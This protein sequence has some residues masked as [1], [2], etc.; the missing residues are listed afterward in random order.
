MPRTP[1]LI[2]RGEPA[3]YHI[4]SRTALP[5]FVLQ[6][7]EKEVLFKIIK[8]ISSVY[9]VDVLGYAIMG[10]H[11]H[12]LVRMNP[13]DRY[14]EEDIKRRY[15]IY[16]GGSSR[17]MIG[18][19]IG[20]YREKWSNLSEYVKEIKQRFAR[21]YNR[22][23]NRRGYFWGDRFK[24][25][26]VERGETLVNCLAYIDLN[27]VRAGIVSK[28]EEYRWCS[29]GYHVQAGN[30]DRFLSMDYGMWGSEGRDEAEKLRNYR[31]YLYE[32]G[33]IEVRGKGKIGEKEV[34]DE[35]RRGYELSRGD[36]LMYRRRYYTEGIVLGSKEFVRSIYERYR[37]YFG[38]KREREPMTVPGLKGIFSL[39]RVSETG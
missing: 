20:Y 6:D 23:N 11:F 13:G 5:G 24:S 9:F 37:G 2:V 12:L 34:E 25:V 35:R 29:I 19:R 3:V 8:H 22:E 36:V 31:M 15:E 4:I 39:K 14:T 30:R 28:P 27:A 38:Y 17:G 33:C 7:A 18:E 21:F 1:R 16:Y 10:N 32:K 26:I